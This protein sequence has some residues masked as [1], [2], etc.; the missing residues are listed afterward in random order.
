MVFV[1][2]HYDLVTNIAKQEDEKCGPSASR[3]TVEDEEDENEWPMTLSGAD[4]NSDEDTQL[5][6]DSI[7]RLSNSIC[8][9]YGPCEWNGVKTLVVKS[10]PYDIDGKCVYEI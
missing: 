3:Q 5:L 10:I 1:D 2:G 9:I 8:R 6:G 7:H 4:E